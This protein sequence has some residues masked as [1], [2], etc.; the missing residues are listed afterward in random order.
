MQYERENECY[1]GIST[2]CT[3]DKYEKN[4]KTLIGGILMHPADKEDDGSVQVTYEK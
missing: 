1:T 2:V 4:S 3:E